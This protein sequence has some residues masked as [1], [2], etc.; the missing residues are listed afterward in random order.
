MIK[1]IRHF[2]IVV[3]DLDR[4]LYFYRDLLGLVEINRGTLTEKETEDYIQVSEKL[5][6]VKLGIKNN[7][8][9][10]I[11]LYNFHKPILNETSSHSHIALTVDNSE[12]IYEELLKEGIGFA[13]K[14]IFDRNKQN[15]VC[16]CK[17]FDQNILELVEE[18][19]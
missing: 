14:P 2:G 19:K 6:Y 4:G 1:N 3:K 11:E 7:L 9:P 12:K 17:D 16:F 18:I 8:Y 5:I 15:K 13:N 10:C